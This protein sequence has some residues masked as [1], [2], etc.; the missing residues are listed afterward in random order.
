LGLQSTH[1]AVAAT[2]SKEGG[3][4]FNRLQKRLKDQL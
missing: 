4:L 1:A 2:W 3:R